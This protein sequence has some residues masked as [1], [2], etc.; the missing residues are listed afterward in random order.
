MGRPS[1]EPGPSV[2]KQ[3]GANEIKAVLCDIRQPLLLIP[4][5]AHRLPCVA[6]YNYAW[7]PPARESIQKLGE[8]AS[9]RRAEKRS[10]FR[11]SPKPGILPSCRIIVAIGFEVGHSSSLRTCSTAGRICW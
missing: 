4:L 10:A 7:P 9:T 3:R 5:K 8:K 6:T 11:L 2:E 1:V